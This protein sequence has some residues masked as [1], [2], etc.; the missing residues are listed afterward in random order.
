MKN[1]GEKGSDSDH[2]VAQE[3]YLLE[4]TE[5]NNKKTHSSR[6]LAIK[7]R[8][9]P[10]LVTMKTINQALINGEKQPLKWWV[11]DVLTT[12]Q[13]IFMQDPSFSSSGDK[14]QNIL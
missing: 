3:F 11:V 10:H 7:L 2:G 5:E 12:K 8:N 1:T 14:D 4:R 6:S 13:F 9:Q